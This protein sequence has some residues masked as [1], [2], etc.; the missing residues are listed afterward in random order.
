ME[1]FLVAPHVDVVRRIGPTHIPDQSVVQAVRIPVHVLVV[2]EP[3][4]PLSIQ[5]EPIEVRQGGIAR[6]AALRRAAPTVGR[7]H[8]VAVGQVGRST[9]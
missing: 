8:N 4:H 2:G 7:K 5:A 1:Q 9:S 3:L 6:H